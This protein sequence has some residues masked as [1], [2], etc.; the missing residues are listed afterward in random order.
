MAVS[1]SGSGEKMVPKIKSMDCK[2]FGAVNAAAQAAMDQWGSLP[3]FS[4]AP[5]E[6]PFAAMGGASRGRVCH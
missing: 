1:G 6:A 5:Y 2:S 3:T 4:I